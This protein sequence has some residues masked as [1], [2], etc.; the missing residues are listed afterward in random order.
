MS[1]LCVNG[2]LIR[3]INFAPAT[4]LLDEEKVPNMQQNECVNT[5]LQTS[6]TVCRLW[7]TRE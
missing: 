2:F 5:Q 1:K 4:L 3:E 7:F 6:Q